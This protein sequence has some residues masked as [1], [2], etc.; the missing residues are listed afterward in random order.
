[1]KSFFL[2]FRKT[3]KYS[4]KVSKSGLIVSIIFGLI[5]GISIFLP[6]IFSEQIVNTLYLLETND[7]G[8]KDIF[9][10]ALIFI[11]SISFC[12]IIKQLLNAYFNYLT[13]FTYKTSDILLA[14]RSLT[15]DYELLE[16]KENKMMIQKA[17]D[18]QNSSGGIGSFLVNIKDIIQYLFL[19][20]LGLI[21]ISKLFIT[22]EIVISKVPTFLE[23]FA[24]SWYSGLVIIVA[25]LLALIITIFFLKIMY[26]ISSDLF[27]KTID[28]NRK[29]QYFFKLSEDYHFG[30]D[31]RIFNLKEVVLKQ[32]DDVNNGLT[33]LFSDT[34]K[35]T[36]FYNSLITLT[37]T[38]VT[39]IGYFLITLKAY[40]KIIEIG[41]II[42]ISGSITNVLTSLTSIFSLFED[43]AIKSKYL[44]YFNDYLS[45]KN[46]EDKEYEDISKIKYPY[47]FTFK[48]VSFKYPNADEYALKNVS[49]TLGK[50]NKTAIVGK[51]GA[52]KSTIIKLIA[53]FYKPDEGEIL[54]NNININKFKFK[55]YQNLFAIVF[56]DFSLFPLT[57]KENVSG[58]K[59]I[60]EDLIK[61]DL[62]KVNFDYSKF[63]KSID[64]YIYKY[65]EDSV[66]L[67]G[68]E[69]QK[70]AIARAL[71]K[72]SPYVFLDEPT[73]ALDPL[74]EA[75]IY[76]LFD[77]L[78]DKK[79]AIYISHRMSSTKFCDDIIVLDKGKIIEEGSHEELMKIKDGIYQE[80]FNAQ[81]KYYK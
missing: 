76:S 1:M 21:Y 50:Y 67:S 81:A 44:G 41:E 11:V 13:F 69:A 18:G 52:G 56:Q 17:R 71:Y 12:L 34:A 23:S 53:R 30:I 16:K 51:N 74:S 24:Y 55:E 49:F 58:N 46:K 57:I 68:G 73:N 33:K 63:S 54:V 10:I 59:E 29:F 35:K 64:T 70:V 77:K 14:K 6:L 26:K 39:S 45:L 2:E 15:L 25:I 8:F 22:K 5:S 66:E 79:K 9:I 27:F 7:L 75:E 4:F 62:D 36:A 42:I 43:L 28:L 20:I 38:L 80:L 32:M 37:V 31:A 72:D 48:N 61:E 47:V 78:V 40:Y 3:L 60:N 65:L 19:L